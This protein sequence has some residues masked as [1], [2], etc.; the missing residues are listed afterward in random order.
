MP[1]LLLHRL[2]VLTVSLP[3]VISAPSIPQAL[4][5]SPALFASETFD[6][7]IVG[8]GTAGL[9]L[10]SRLTEVPTVRVGVIEAGA[11]IAPG[12]D[13][14]IDLISEYGAAFG[15]PEFDWELQ[16]IPQ[17]GLGGRVVNETVARVLGG[18]S[19]INDVLW[20]R[21]SRE[22]YNSWGTVLGNG[23]SWSFDALQPYFRKAENWDG[24][25]TVSLPGERNLT[26]A[27]LTPHGESGPI[28]L[29]Y[30]NFI[31]DPVKRAVAAANALGI[32]SNVNPDGGNATGFSSPLRAVDPQ[33]GTRSSVVTAYFEPSA[34]RGNLVVLTGAQATRIV[35]DEKSK[36]STA[37]LKAIGVN[38]IAGGSN[39]TVVAKKEV[40]V[41]TGTFK[42]P[43][44]LELS[45]IGDR[46]LLEK[47]GI[48]VLVDLPGVGENLQDQTYTLSDFV[49]K[50]GVVT[51]DQL[52]FNETFVQ[53]QQ[54]QFA[55]NHTGVLTYDTGTTGSTPLSAFLPQSII[56]DLSS[57]MP[58]AASNLTPLQN[59]QYDLMRKIMYEGKV[60]WV[61]LLMLAGGGAASVPEED[62]SYVTPIVFHLYPFSR[63]SVH[64][65]S[66]DPLDPASIDPQY[67]SHD[68]GKPRPYVAIHAVTMAWTRKWMQTPPMSDLIERANVPDEASV[69]TTEEW[70]DYV[71]GNAITALHPIG[72]AALAPEHLRGENLRPTPLDLSAHH[73]CIRFRAGVVAPNFKV[74]RTSNLRVVDA[75]VIPL[76][77]GVAP[78]ATVYAIAEKA[79]DVIK[80]EAC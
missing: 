43:Q 44:I 6:Y 57:L 7:V 3:A 79:A 11:Y 49:V 36:S 74:H 26:E 41:S 25:P 59:V 20:Q 13:P 14:R 52:R 35:F 48:E 16:T 67:F 22:E 4:R 45:G 18:S 61:E 9:V 63:G 62:T 70:A 21:A 8:G 58:S 37:G 64:I 31:P 39:H 30:N 55:S 33:T 80:W 71:R 69:N 10:A 5:I 32:R 12:T 27:A 65:N 66:T 76:T 19:M 40:I 50:N 1:R 47:Y 68:F 29:S 15:D 56:R 54:A 23:P 17:E 53:E 77:F 75:S 51:L 34:Q 78:L 72:T 28:K 2:L 42:T 24:P 73:F 38:F 46:S 60:G